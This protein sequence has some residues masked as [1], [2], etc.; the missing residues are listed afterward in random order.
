MARFAWQA[1]SIGSKISIRNKK[2]K[3]SLYIKRLSK[4]NM[5]KQNPRSRLKVNIRRRKIPLLCLARKKVIPA[6]KSAESPVV[7]FLRLVILQLHLQTKIQR[8][9][10]GIRTIQ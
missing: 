1:T 4:I 5:V 9:P 8:M 10:T 7:I 3:V 6:R 2:L